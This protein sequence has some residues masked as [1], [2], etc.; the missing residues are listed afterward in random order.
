MN[1]RYLTPWLT[2]FS[3][4][5]YGGIEKCIRNNWPFVLALLP[6]AEQPVFFAQPTASN[7]DGNFNNTPENDLAFFITPFGSCIQ[8]FIKPE[9]SLTEVLSLEDNHAPD[10]ELELECAT[11]KGDYLDSIADLIKVL[12][13]EGGKTVISMVLRGNL[14]P[15][16]FADG[17]YREIFQGN[18][19]A[20]RVMFFTPQTGLWI[21]ATPELL[22]SVDKTS[23][24]FKTMALAGT[25]RRGTSGGWDMKNSREQG[26]VT[27]F[28]A[29]VLSK[30]GAT[31]AQETA[32]LI[33]NNIEHL[34][35]YFTGN[36]NGKKFGELANRLH[37]TPAV[38]GTPRAESLERIARYEKHNRRFYAGLCGF[39]TPTEMVCY[40]TLRCAQIL[41]NEYAVYA[42]GGITAQSKPQSE[43]E[44]V[45]L[46]ASPIVKILEGQKCNY[47]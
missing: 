36:L 2:G 24:A 27:N 17:K 6:G 26:M 35:T 4:E 10:L 47:R 11:D 8:I 5:L 20:F 41:G 21:A 9:V 34:C 25:R 43:W 39:T 19:T 33:S 37:P 16:F 15:R 14:C 23:G 40:V 44:E 38:C 46:K 30:A 7:Q 1:I 45:N 12:G 42:G 18:P 3:Q 31:F 32:T 29:Q 22:L 13:T 28:I